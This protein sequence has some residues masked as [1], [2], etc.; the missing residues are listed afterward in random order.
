MAELHHRS[1]WPP[2]HEPLAKLGAVDNSSA[3]FP[4]FR[5]RKDAMAEPRDRFKRL[6][7]DTNQVSN[8]GTK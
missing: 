7:G 1:K 8:S 3:L 6:D 5:R 4:F 2:F